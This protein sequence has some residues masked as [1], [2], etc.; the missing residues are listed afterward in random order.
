MCIFVL[1]LLKTKC[2]KNNFPIFECVSLVRCELN[3]F[4]QLLEFVWSRLRLRWC[5]S[6]RRRVSGA[7][8]C[9][10]WAWSIPASDL[11]YRLG[12]G[13]I[14]TPGQS[15]LI[16]Y[17]HHMSPHSCFYRLNIVIFN[18]WCRNQRPGAAIIEFCLDLVA[19]VRVTNY[20]YG[21]CRW[22]EGTTPVRPIVVRG[23]GK[24]YCVIQ[25]NCGNFL[26]EKY[27]PKCVLG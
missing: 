3:S 5:S 8:V 6:R 2:I 25:K 17:F 7:K 9:Q 1:H 13:G 12:S 16:Q 18:L 10:S 23:T 19:D 24:F 11:R 26:S 21:C 27:R 20:N 4:P 22:F 14:W 15:A